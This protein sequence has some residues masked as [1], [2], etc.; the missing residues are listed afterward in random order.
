MTT[1]TPIEERVE[2]VV[3]RGAAR[4]QN[5]ETA[6]NAAGIFIAAGYEFRCPAGATDEVGGQHWGISSLWPICTPSDGTVH[7]GCYVEVNVDRIGPS[8]AL[9]RHVI[10]HEF[11][12]T[13]EYVAT[14]TTSELA[15]DACAAAAGFPRPN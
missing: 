11:C 9:L 5:A 15:A 14:G 8:D 10:A 12:H 13:I 6:V 1:A 3:V 2:H 4:C 7:S